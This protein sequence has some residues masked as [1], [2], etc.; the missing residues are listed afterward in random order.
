VLSPGS[1]ILLETINVASWSAFFSSYL[2]DITHMR[3][4]HPDTLR[5]LVD[6]AGFADTEVQLRAP[7]PAAQQLGRTPEV[8]RLTTAPGESGQGLAALYNSIDRNVNL[9]NDLIFAPQDYAVVGWK[10]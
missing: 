2:R 10:R 6:A 9:L 4:L 8:T 5:F 7:I 3:P 1:P